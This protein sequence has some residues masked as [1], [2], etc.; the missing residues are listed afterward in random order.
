[1]YP[2]SI[3]SINTKWFTQWHFDRRPMSWLCDRSPEILCEWQRNSELQH[4]SS[5][6]QPWRYPQI[7]LRQRRLQIEPWA[8][9]L[10]SSKTSS[11]SFIF[12]F[13]VP[14]FFKQG[15]PQCFV[16][17]PGRHL[18]KCFPGRIT[19]LASDRHRNNN[20]WG[21]MG[22]DHDFFNAH[23]CQWVFSTTWRR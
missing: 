19:G 18:A 8:L 1:M 14:E 4:P 15:L 21:P 10:F 13:L 7:F 5:G 6:N 23:N 2:K 11:K 9:T 16:R 22:E 17:R 12:S 3:N 20:Y